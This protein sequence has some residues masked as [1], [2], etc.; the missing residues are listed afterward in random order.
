MRSST[1]DSIV[2]VRL[3]CA[4]VQRDRDPAVGRP[5]IVDAVREQI[6]EAGKTGSPRAV[7]RK[8]GVS[9]ETVRRFAADQR[10][11][12]NLGDGNPL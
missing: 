8:F 9:V 11:D 4:D 1:R 2:E 10:H 3:R 7:A 5:K 6:V 12:P